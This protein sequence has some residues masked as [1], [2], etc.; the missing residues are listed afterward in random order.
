MT[1]QITI[2]RLNALGREGGSRFTWPALAL[3]DTVDRMPV[4][5]GPGDYARWLDVDQLDP[6]ALL[7]LPR[8]RDDRLSRFDA[9]QL[10]KE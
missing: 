8:R 5:L 2:S 1:P 4:V 7:P 6:E 9:R 3:P 10:A